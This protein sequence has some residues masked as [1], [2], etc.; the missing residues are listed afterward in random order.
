MSSVTEITE[1]VAMTSYITID[2]IVIER[3]CRHK[4]TISTGSR[5][6]DNRENPKPSIHT[7]VVITLSHIL[8]RLGA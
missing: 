4:M 6:V 5:S 2:D 7:A 3:S 1:V 8:P